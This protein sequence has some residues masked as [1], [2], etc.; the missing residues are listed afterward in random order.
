LGVGVGEGELGLVPSPFPKSSQLVRQVIERASQVVDDMTETDCKTRIDF[1]DVSI[2]QGA[3]FDLPAFKVGF[4][5]DLDRQG[6]L[7]C[8]DSSI[9]FYEVLMRA[10]Q[11][12]DAAV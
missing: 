1:G 9:E 12:Q 5:C 4:E 3:G 2:D 11:R 8:A 7:I 10:I 6:I